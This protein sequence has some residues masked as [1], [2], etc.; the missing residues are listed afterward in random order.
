VNLDEHSG[1]PPPSSTTEISGDQ[2][3][4]KNHDQPAENRTKTSVIASLLASGYTLGEDA[5]AKARK[6][7]DD[8]QLSTKVAFAVGATK[9]KISQ[10]DQAY[11]IS[12]TVGNFAH[13]VSHK[14]KEVDQN[15]K[16][17]EN[18]QNIM[19][20]VSDTVGVMQTKANEIP[21][22]QTTMHTLSHIAEN[23]SNFISPGVQVITQGAQAINQQISSQAAQIREESNQIIEE[24]RRAKQEKE[25]N[26]SHE[27]STNSISNNNATDQQPPHQP[28]EHHLD[29]HT[30]I[31]SDVL[32][33][34]KVDPPK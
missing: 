2:I 24:N 13:D 15:W 16:I 27:D 21:A 22:V 30:E 31:G 17:T 4:N 5:I 34:E 8:N 6:I 7:D 19:K 33:P 18:V 10:I 20:N 23:V 14:A 1:T 25:G 3:P 9:E 29:E 28:E 12:E 11:H 26:S 32:T